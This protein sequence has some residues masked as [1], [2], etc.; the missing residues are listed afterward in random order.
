MAIFNGLKTAKNDL[1]KLSDIV[2]FCLDNVKTNMQ[3]QDLIDLG[4]DILS[5]SLTI[6]QA[7]IPFDNAY[8]LASI[9]GASVIQIDLE[10]NKRLLHA[11]L[12]E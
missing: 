10:E 8:N 12:Y 3:A 4:M 7:R 1:V 11:Y 2:L 5:Q 9:N 6:D